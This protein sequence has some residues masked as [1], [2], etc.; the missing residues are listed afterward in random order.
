MDQLIMPSTVISSI[1]YHPDSSTLTI[2]Y[3]SGIV[4]QYKNVPEKVYK[5]LKASMSKGRYLNYHIKRKYDFE[6]VK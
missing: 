5:E 4:Y 2:K 6:K 3:V 1:Q